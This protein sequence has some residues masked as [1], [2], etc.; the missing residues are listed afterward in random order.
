MAFSSSRH[1]PDDIT[2]SRYAL[3]TGTRLAQVPSANIV[4]PRK[5][6]HGL[7]RIRARIPYTLASG[8]EDIHVPAFW[9]LL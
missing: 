5:L 6:E 9:L 8:H 7:R 2:S 3:Q 1:G 4:N